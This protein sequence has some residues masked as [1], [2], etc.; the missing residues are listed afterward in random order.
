M[1]DDNQL[2]PWAPPQP[3]GVLHRN[4]C[5]VPP[6]HFRDTV[7]CILASNLEW[8]VRLA[9]LGDL[10]VLAQRQTFA[11][12]YQV[13]RWVSAAYRSMCVAADV[14]LTFLV[15]ALDQQD[16]L[17]IPYE[18]SFDPLRSPGLSFLLASN[19]SETCQGIEA[20]LKRVMRSQI[21]TDMR[22]VR[23]SFNHL[24]AEYIPGSPWIRE[25]TFSQTLL[26]EI[27]GG[28]GPGSVER[29]HRLCLLERARFTAMPERRFT[30][31]LVQHPSWATT[32][33]LLSLAPSGLPETR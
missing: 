8:S 6:G 29:V 9:F 19:V 15:A 1:R 3:Y 18:H 27:N 22:V 30:E 26:H 17:L 24:C 13:R 12:G 31:E 11:T 4:L 23:R 25:N 5:P 14:D 7:I 20:F 21:V 32:E 33:A 10:S 28:P 2:F 16:E